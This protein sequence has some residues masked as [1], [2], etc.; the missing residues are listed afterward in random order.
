[1]HTE[2]NQVNAETE[3]AAGA[4]LVRRESIIHQFMLANEVYRHMS[5][6]H[7]YIILKVMNSSSTI[8]EPS[9]MNLL[10]KTLKESDGAINYF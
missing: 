10:L 6:T 1:L 7:M 8:H 4:L 3:L 2:I 9:T 5:V